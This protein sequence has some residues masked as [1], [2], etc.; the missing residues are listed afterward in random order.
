MF[1]LPRLHHVWKTVKEQLLKRLQ[2]ELVWAQ[3]SFM[4]YVQSMEYQI[5]IGY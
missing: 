1:Y 3:L 4:Y 2:M 5:L